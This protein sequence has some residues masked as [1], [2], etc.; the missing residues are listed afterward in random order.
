MTLLFS[1][2]ATAP[3]AT[4]LDVGVFDVF[5]PTAESKLVGDILPHSNYFIVLSSS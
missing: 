1:G 5:R 3:P 4:R 2:K